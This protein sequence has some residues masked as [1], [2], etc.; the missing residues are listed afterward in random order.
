MLDTVIATFSLILSVIILIYTIKTLNLTKKEQKS[1]IIEE[2]LH[3]FYNPLKELLEGHA[4]DEHR[5]HSIIQYTYLADEDIQDK[6]AAFLYNPKLKGL[7]GEDWNKAEQIKL[8]QCNELLMDVS[9]KIN[10]KEKELLKLRK[11]KNTR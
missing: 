9:T 5:Y 3:N 10:E 6:F 4:V 8:V 2:S 1:R 11:I 7:T